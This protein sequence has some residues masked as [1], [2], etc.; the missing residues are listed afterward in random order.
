MKNLLRR[1]CRPFINFY[2]NIEECIYW[3]PIIWKDQWWDNCFLMK[4]MEMKIRRDAD[5]YEKWGMSVKAN[6]YAQKMRLAAVLL[7]R[8]Q[9]DAYTTP[10]DDEYQEYLHRFS[11]HM[12]SHKIEGENGMTYYSTERFVKDKRDD[13]VF[14]W[15]SN[16]LKQMRKQDKELLF[17]L[18][19]KHILEAWD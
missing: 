9:E 14:R 1:M 15:Q 10:W 2:W 5:R 19:D 3:L 8:L 17:K 16:H 4:M 7:S 6:K 18:L 12:L 11:I 13:D